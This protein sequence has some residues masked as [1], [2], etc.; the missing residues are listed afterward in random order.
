TPAN[1]RVMNGVAYFNA[2]KFWRSDGSDQGTYELANIFTPTNLTDVNGTLFF[3]GQGG[4]WRTDGTQGGTVQVTNRVSNPDEFCAV[5]NRL[6]FRGYDGG[7]AELWTSDGT[8][9][10]TYRVKDINAG[11]A[12][13]NPRGLTASNGR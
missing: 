11:G 13:S 12:S 9:A 1:I 7:G 3:A 4:L 5:G 6:Y 2:F 10:G 8:D